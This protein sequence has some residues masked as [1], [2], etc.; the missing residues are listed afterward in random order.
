MSP[1]E[2]TQRVLSK[3]TLI[4]AGIG[5]VCAL[6]L[7]GGAYTFATDQTEARAERRELKTA[8][9]NLTDEIQNSGLATLPDRI[10]RIER[11]VALLAKDA[12]THKDAEILRLQLREQGVLVPNRPTP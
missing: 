3:D 4:P 2:I 8:L 9:Q 11:D 6:G 10:G 7:A 12:F 1:A 5:M